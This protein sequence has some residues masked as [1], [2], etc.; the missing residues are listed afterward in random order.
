M[1]W[2]EYL[3]QQ[4]GGNFH[5][6][7]LTLDEDDS[8]GTMQPPAAASLPR[9]CVSEDGS[10]N[11]FDDADENEDEVLEMV[12]K[13]RNTLIRE[14]FN[15]A[16]AA[17]NIV[18]LTNTTTSERSSSSMRSTF[19]SISSV[20]TAMRQGGTRRLQERRVVLVQNS[21]MMEFLATRM[22]LVLDAEREKIAVASGEQADGRRVRVSM[23]PFAQ[24]GLRN[25]Y[26]M[27]QSRNQQQVAKESRHDIK[28]QERL[29]FHFETAKC[30]AKAQTYA[31]AF[32]KKLKKGKVAVERIQFL[33]TEVYRLKD[34]NYP[35]GFRYL[36]V[37]DEMK[38]DYV[39]WN[40]NNG[41]V[42]D[43]GSLQCHMAHAF[44]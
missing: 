5:K 11:M 7:N 25:V 44:R 43:D 40:G 9:H 13:S 41:Y 20:V 3:A 17:G 6:P 39:K 16:R 2:L 36:G 12:V 10:D 33:K 28:Y 29:K 4:F 1:K 26:R 38:G 8:N 22:V 42:K 15:R 24:G 34:S 27:K 32:N 21:P 37:E 14:K 30:Q 18:S 19:Q 23:H 35:G 31:K